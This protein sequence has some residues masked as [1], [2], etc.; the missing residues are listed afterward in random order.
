MIYKENYRLQND[1]KAQ[2]QNQH[3]L[4]CNC[5]RFEFGIIFR[6]PGHLFLTKIWRR[7][8]AHSVSQEQS[9][10]RIISFV[11]MGAR[12]EPV[13]NVRCTI[14]EKSIEELCIVDV[15][16]YICVTHERLQ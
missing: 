6:H 2:Q 16:L 10:L 11:W 4:Q 1:E 12:H 8:N 15:K 13:T 3:R 7:M 14:H 5:N 9:Q